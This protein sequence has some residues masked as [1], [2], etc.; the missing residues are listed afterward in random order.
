MFQWNCNGQS[1]ETRSS[2]YRFWFRRFPCWDNQMNNCLILT[3]RVDWFLDEQ[4]I[5]N[6]WHILL[7]VLACWWLSKQ[8]ITSSLL[9]HQHTGMRPLAGL[10]CVVPWSSKSQCTV[11]WWIPTM[12]G[13]QFHQLLGSDLNSS[14]L[15]QHQDVM[16]CDGQMSS[17][18]FIPLFHSYNLINSKVWLTDEGSRE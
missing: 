1:K 6:V 5:N 9:E 15:S 7:F 13:W 14:Q 10:S 4:D 18:F 17:I 8:V 2:V 12:M 11:M 16:R 3:S